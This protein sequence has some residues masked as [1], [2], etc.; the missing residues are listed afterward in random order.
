MIPAGPKTGNGHEDR[1]QPQTPNRGY[2]R[3]VPRP[4]P[5][6]DQV[7]RSADGGGR[8][9]CLFVPLAFEIPRGV[10]SPRPELFNSSL[11]SDS[12]MCVGRKVAKAVELETIAAHDNIRWSL[13][14]GVVEMPNQTRLWK[15]GERKVNFKV[16]ENAVRLLAGCTEGRAHLKQ[17]GNKLDPDLD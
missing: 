11:K 5:K 8:K 16:L 7:Q 4:V 1:I 6:K 15:G 14:G 9:T 3:P 13:E 10:A 12:D 2:G 17:F